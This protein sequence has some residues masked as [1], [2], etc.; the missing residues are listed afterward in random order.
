MGKKRKKPAPLEKKAKKV[1]MLRRFKAAVV[2][3][4]QFLTK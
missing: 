1:P 2:R 4:G 3:A